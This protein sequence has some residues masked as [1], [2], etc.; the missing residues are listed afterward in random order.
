[1]RQKL[2]KEKV[3]TAIKN[4]LIKFKVVSKKKISSLTPEELRSKYDLFH[5]NEGHSKAQ[6]KEFKRPDMAMY[7][8]LHAPAK[9]LE[10][11]RVSFDDQV[12]FKSSK[13]AA[14]R[15]ER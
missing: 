7:M 3:Q 14:R 10:E 12:K 5:K 9:W 15:K 11:K 4:L 6:R 8:E 2:Q 1:M 13:L